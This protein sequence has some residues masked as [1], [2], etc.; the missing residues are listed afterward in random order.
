LVQL[1]ALLAP[2]GRD[3]GLLRRLVDGVQHGIHGRLVDQTVESL[4]SGSRH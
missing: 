3:Q 1:P 2:G 4:A